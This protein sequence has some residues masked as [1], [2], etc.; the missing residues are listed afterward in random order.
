MFLDAVEGK[1][2]ALPL[3][4]PAEAASRSAVM[5]ALYKASVA[6]KRVALKKRG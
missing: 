2:T 6:R 4:T 5:E 3:V 1:P